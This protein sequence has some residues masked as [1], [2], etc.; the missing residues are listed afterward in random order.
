MPAQ[1]RDSHVTES[2]SERPQ[3][4]GTRFQIQRFEIR[5]MPDDMPRRGLLFVA[6]LIVVGLIAGASMR[7]GAEMASKRQQQ[8][9]SK[10]EGVAKVTRRQVQEQS[11]STSQPARIILPAT[12]EENSN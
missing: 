5:R 2:Q 11:S 1:L 8:A 3:F 10:S 6:T 4:P 9:S 7:L 12:F